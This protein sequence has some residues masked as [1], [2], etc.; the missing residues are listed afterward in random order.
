MHVH[1][2]ACV[3]LNLHICECIQGQA[4]TDLVYKNCLLQFLSCLL[5]T[6]TFHTESICTSWQK[7]HQCSLEGIAAQRFTWACVFTHYSTD[8][9]KHDFKKG[10]EKICNQSSSL[11]VFYQRMSHGSLGEQS[12]FTIF[13]LSK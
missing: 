12:L 8:A 11:P 9:C 7:I 10:R 4:Y 13:L 1:L 3:L 6:N 5:P 2:C